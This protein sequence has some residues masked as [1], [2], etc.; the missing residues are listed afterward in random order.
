MNATTHVGAEIGGE[1][2]GRNRVLG[3]RHDRKCDRRQ[4]GLDQLEIVLA[5]AIDMIRREREPPGSRK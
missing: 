4:H 1:Q 5:K 2:L 3:I